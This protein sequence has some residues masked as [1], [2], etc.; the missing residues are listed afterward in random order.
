MAN[1]KPLAEME[2]ADSNAPNELLSIDLALLPPRQY[3]ESPRFTQTPSRHL[4]DTP[5]THYKL[6]IEHFLATGRKGDSLI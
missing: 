6:K 5:Q 3:P 1:W 2:P 4:P